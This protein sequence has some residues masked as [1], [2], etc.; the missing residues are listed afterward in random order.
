M[1]GANWLFYMRCK[2]LPSVYL[3]L[4]VA[5][6][7]PLSCIS[8]Q[9][10]A[11][12]FSNELELVSNLSKNITPPAIF[13]SNGDPVALP[14]AGELKSIFFNTLDYDG[15][16]TKSY[17]LIGLPKNASEES[18]VPAVV[19]VH[20]GGGS[21]FKVWVE[22]WN[23]KGYAAISIAVEGQTDEKIKEGER[24]PQDWAIHQWAGPQRK[25][26]YG[27]ASKEFKDQWMYHAVADTIIANSLIRSL[28]SVN[29]EKVGL[30]GISW[31]G[32]ITSTVIGI[33]E[34]F[35]FAIP[36]YG[37]GSLAESQNIY[38]KSLKGNELYKQVWDP[39]V[40]IKN[41]K[42]PLLWM[43]WPEDS[44][45]SLD[46]QR[47]CYDATPTNDSI[48]LV[49]KMG[50]GHGP[51]WNAPDSYAF[52]DSITKNG[53]PW[54]ACVIAEHK[55][56]E[57]TVKFETSKPL[58]SATLV[59]SLES[60]Y[61]GDRQWEETSAE[62]NQV[63]GIWEAKVTTPEGATGWFVNVKSGGLTLSSPYITP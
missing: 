9:A 22:K 15:K 6:A 46:R 36:V 11:S 53:K 5:L 47:A 10:V 25:G 41:A 29:D 14:K 44:H 19:L 23:A 49:P 57:T 43:S 28:P 30:M 34:R 4:Q 31:G 13:D 24:T 52:A 55:G 18:K 26:I 7:V 39:M 63:S 27:D 51:G 56:G 60:G 42:I 38:G 12:D 16:P 21:A 58:D 8:G 54:G 32:V 37:C 59:Y 40:R 20:G 33:D 61:T 35:A 45:F 62:L 2:T 17:A 48:C 50:H 3:L 1:R